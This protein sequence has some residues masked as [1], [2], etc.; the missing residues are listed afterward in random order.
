MMTHDLSGCINFIV[1][2][3]CADELHVILAAL[4]QVAN[5][6]GTI[7]I[8][9]FIVEILDELPKTD[10]CCCVCQTPKF[11]NDNGVDL[12]GKCGELSSWKVTND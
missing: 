8:N 3:H 12:C 10:T 4:Y 5:E 6:P 2:N 11:Y 9:D 1:E 7:G